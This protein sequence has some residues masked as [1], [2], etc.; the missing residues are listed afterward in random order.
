M[1]IYVFVGSAA[2]NTCPSNTHMIQTTNKHHPLQYPTKKRTQVNTSD[3]EAKLDLNIKLG[4]MHKHM[5]GNVQYHTKLLPRVVN[6]YTSNTQSMFFCRT[7]INIYKHVS[8][9]YD[10]R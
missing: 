8:T 2:P 3:S 1:H 7:D 10:S 9:S 4:T 5:D 6:G